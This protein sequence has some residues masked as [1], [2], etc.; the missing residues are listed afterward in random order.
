M[1][2]AFVLS[3]DQTL[4]CTSPGAPKNTRL[5]NGI[6]SSQ[7]A[8][9]LSISPALPQLPRQTS[10]RQNP[11]ARSQTGKTNR[12]QN[13]RSTKRSEC[14]SRSEEHTS[15]LQSLM[16]NSYA[17]FCLKKKK[18]QKLKNQQISKTDLKYII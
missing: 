12:S 9:N 6:L 15:E 7:N 18:H 8:R 2:P 14:R 10:K 17:V 3:Q 16:R 13:T 5:I 1:P 11:K 4:R